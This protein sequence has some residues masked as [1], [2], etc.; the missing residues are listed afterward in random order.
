ELLASARLALDQDCEIRRGE[1]LDAIAHLTDRPAR[2]DQRRGAVG[3]RP[4]QRR[5][6]P[7]PP[8]PPARPRR[9]A[10]RPPGAASVRTAPA[11][12]VPAPS[13]VPAPPRAL[14]TPAARRSSRRA[15]APD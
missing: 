9:P 15:S 11:A 14:P 12:P 2:P 10:P 7:P 6:P 1:P 5:R 3:P 13:R 4:G 8:P